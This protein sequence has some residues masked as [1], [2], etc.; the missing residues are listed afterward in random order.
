MDYDILAE[1]FL[2]SLQKLRKA[3]QK[4]NISD[5]VQGESFIL[6]YL[7]EKQGYVIPKDISTAMGISTARIA[8]VLNSLENKGFVS[9]IIDKTDRR[10]ILVELTDEGLQFTKEQRAEIKEQTS[11]MLG[12]LGGQDA[13]EFIRLMN[14]LTARLSE[15]DIQIKDL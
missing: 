8:A 13:K 12:L 1:E 10:R 15:A 2:R 7:Y 9:R 14:K 3:R 11:R 5:C 6:A 4:I